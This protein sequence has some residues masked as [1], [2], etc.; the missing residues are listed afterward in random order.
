MHILSPFVK[1]VFLRAE[2]FLDDNNEPR[3]Y[4]C[5]PI[6][7]EARNIKYAIEAGEVNL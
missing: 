3:Y 2:S 7:Y 5:E 4:W 6:F 1:Y